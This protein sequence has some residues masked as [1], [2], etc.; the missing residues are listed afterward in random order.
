MSDNVDNK[1]NVGGANSFFFNDDDDDDSL[2]YDQVDS[3]TNFEN[4][5][6]DGCRGHSSLTSACIF[7]L[8]LSWFDNKEREMAIEMLKDR[9]ELRRGLRGLAPLSPCVRRLTNDERTQALKY[10]KGRAKDLR[11]ARLAKMAPTKAKQAV[12]RVSKMQKP[13]KHQLTKMAGRKTVRPLGPRSPLG[14]SNV[15]RVARKGRAALV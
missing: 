6:N 12:K 1:V 4:T 2:A 13:A 10:V 15:Q 3:M 7:K 9:L 11:Q 14:P 5:I 8:D